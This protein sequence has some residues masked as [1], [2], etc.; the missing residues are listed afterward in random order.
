MSLNMPHVTKWV[1]SCVL[2][3]IFYYKSV[4]IFVFE[5][6]S[7]HG[8]LKICFLDQKQIYGYEDLQMLQSRLPLVRQSNLKTEQPTIFIFCNLILSLTCSTNSL[9]FWPFNFFFPLTNILR[10]DL[11]IYLFLVLAWLLWCNIP[12]CYGSN[13]WKR[14]P[15]Q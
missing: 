8:L 13:A 9:N 1:K 10:C 2:C 7:C 4:W 12:W 6:C 3:H 11:F 14:W 15:A 5:V